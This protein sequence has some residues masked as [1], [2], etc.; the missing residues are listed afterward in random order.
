MA[1]NKNMKM[2]YNNIIMPHQP[3]KQFNTYKEGL[4]LEFFDDRSGKLITCR[5]L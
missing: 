2:V 1:N 3:N 4:D 5:G